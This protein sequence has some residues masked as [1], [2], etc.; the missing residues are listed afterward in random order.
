MPRYLMTHSLLA[1]WL[2]AMKENPYEDSTS[3]SDP[4]A[5]FLRVLNRTPTETTEAMQRGIYFENLVTNITRGCG[6][7]SDS[8]Y[9]AAEAV[10]GKIIGAPLQVKAYREIDVDGTRILLHGRLD[11]LRAGTIYDIKYSSKYERGKYF[12][13]TQHPM[14]FELIPEA[15]RFIY[16]VSNGNDVWTE[17]YTREETQSIVPIISAFFDFLRQSDLADTY[18]SKWAVKG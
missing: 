6:D 2:Y 14:Y 11:A 7:K 3:E 9:S 13:S 8:W 1:S 16:L 4:Y 17:T 18:R 5:D 15:K 10:A 12:G